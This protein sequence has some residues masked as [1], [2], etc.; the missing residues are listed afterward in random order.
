[1]IKEIK[2]INEILEF[3]WCISRDN[4][5]NSYTK[6]TSKDQLIKDLEFA[7]KSD[8]RKVIS[9]YENNILKGACVYYWLKEDKYAQ[10]T[11]FMIDSNFNIIAD[12]II[13][14]IGA[15]LPGYEL[16]IGF[17]FDNVNAT[18]YFKERNIKCIESSFDTRLKTE[19][20]I[21]KDIEE[22]VETVDLETFDE[23]AI[24]HDEYAKKLEMYW[25]SDRLKEHINEFKIY[26]YRCEGKIRG[27]I[28]VR[29]YTKSA[30]I[31]GLFLDENFNNK[32]IE[33]DLIQHTLKSIYKEYEPI[34]EVTYF[35]DE[36]SKD[37]LN[38]A[39]GTGFK[40]NDTYRCCK[41]EL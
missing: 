13:K 24:F 39:L 34:E 3:T 16:F 37:E 30:E 26:V 35:I 17:P 6:R 12:E 36:E 5:K 41:C 21:E 40:I 7:I 33:S 9:C 20:Y 29:K 14:Y 15:E 18:E 28:F 31:F 25:T 10:T 8:T 38:I 11:V 19:N 32:G 23:Y 1:M 2:D 22:E 27:S 4:T